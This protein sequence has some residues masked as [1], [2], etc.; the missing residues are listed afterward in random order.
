MKLVYILNLISFYFSSLFDIYLLLFT[1]ANE[2]CTQIFAVLLTGSPQ[3][4]NSIEYNCLNQS[5]HILQTNSFFMGL[6]KIG[7]NH[8]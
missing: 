7:Q 5:V 6:G 1:I 8:F 4:K 3:Q 2:H